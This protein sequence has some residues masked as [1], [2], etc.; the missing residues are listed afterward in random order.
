MW[1]QR[2]KCCGKPSDANRGVSCVYGAASQSFTVGHADLGLEVQPLQVVGVQLHQLH[3]TDTVNVAALA[4][5]SSL[6]SGSKLTQS[7][8]SENRVLK[9]TLTRGKNFIFSLFSRAHEAVFSN[10]ILSVVCMLGIKSKKTW[11]LRCAFSQLSLCQ[12][13]EGM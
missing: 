2:V 11:G 8:Y 4:N 13:R 1:G 5:V 6:E 12:H 10:T 7:R 3:S 9:Y